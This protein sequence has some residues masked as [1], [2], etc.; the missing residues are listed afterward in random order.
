VIR[1]PNLGWDPVS[2]KALVSQAQP[3]VFDK[4]DEKMPINWA[5]VAHAFNPSTPEV[6]AGRFLSSRPAWSIKW[7]PGQPGLYRE[8]LSQKTKQKN[9]KKKKKT[10]KPINSEKQKILIYSI[11]SHWDEVQR[12]RVAVL[13]HLSGPNMGGGIVSTEGNL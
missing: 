9:P 2:L 11:R 12:D 8:T 7:V 1:L 6:E 13:G 10:K 5:V 4:T 3:P